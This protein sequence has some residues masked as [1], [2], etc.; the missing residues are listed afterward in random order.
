[1]LTPLAHAQNIE[2]LKQGVV[3]VLSSL[4]DGVQKTGTGFI[5]KTAPDRAYVVT[6]T[7]V[8]QGA[9]RIE[10]EFFAKRDS[11]VAAKV[12]K[13]EDDSLRGIAYLVVS[14][15]A[16]AGALPL[17][18]APEV[19]LSEGSEEVLTLGFP[20]GAPGWS[21]KSLKFATR[22]GRE[23]LFDG[24]V[25]QGNSGGPLL[26]GGQVVGL[27]QSERNGY[28]RANPASAV[29]EFLEG[30]GINVAT[31]PAAPVTAA[32]EV[33]APAAT[34][35][36]SGGA[37]PSADADTT[38]EISIGEVTCDPD[39]R[40]V[41]VITTGRARGPIGT[42]VMIDF[43]QRGD[44]FDSKLDCG[45]WTRWA[46]GVAC[47]REQSAPETTVWRDTSQLS[48][49]PQVAV[50][51]L[52]QAVA[53]EEVSPVK[54][55]QCRIERCDKVRVECAGQLRS[56]G[57]PA[58]PSQAKPPSKDAVAAV[59]P[60]FSWGE[61][62]KRSG[63]LVLS[64]RGELWL[65]TVGGAERNPVS[66]PAELAIIGNKYFV[67]SSLH[68]H[69]L[70]VKFMIAT[71]RITSGDFMQICET[72]AKC[73]APNRGTSAADQEFRS[74]MQIFFLEV[75]KTAMRRTLDQ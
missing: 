7:H 23:L 12:G 16:P 42:L 65:N 31:R 17:L 53:G 75:A 45:A 72:G 29:L 19:Q 25:N 10:V 74:K 56:P 38:S 64:T 35:S 6:A 68:A 27:V 49:T 47:V 58:P 26:K 73:V 28:V 60:R 22:D 66:N 70:P 36:S 50:A 2:N 37:A 48:A 14:T 69:R 9:Q 8:V 51:M 59:S 67:S 40:H 39:G 41:G 57:I 44:F 61:T 62:V 18:L 21:P 55:A 13:M 3:R 4:E 20:Q 11:L 1:L 24:K 34:Q 52:G 46:H 30:S 15:P 71:D 43:D 63:H 54:L 32:P 33:P 5:V